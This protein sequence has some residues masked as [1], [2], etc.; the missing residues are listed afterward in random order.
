MGGREEARGVVGRSGVVGRV[1]R[2]RER[3]EVESHRKIRLC[4]G[5]NIL[6]ISVLEKQ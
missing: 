6:G 1:G 2:W 4:S 5:N 3:G